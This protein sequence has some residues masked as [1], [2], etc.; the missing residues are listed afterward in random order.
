MAVFCC[1]FE[2]VLYHCFMR[3][4]SIDKYADTDSFK[5]IYGLDEAGRGPWAGPVVACALMFKSPG[6][7]HGCNDSKALTGDERERL[8][9]KLQD[10]AYY[11]IGMATHD[12]ID[13]MGLRKATNLAFSRAL[14]E[15]KTKGAPEPDFLLIDGRDR[16]Q[17]PYPFKTIIK[18]DSKVRI[19]SAASIMAKVSRDRL[20][21]E[22]AVK[23]PDYG[24]EEHKGYGT[25]MHQKAIAKNGLCE[26]H[27]KS[28]KPVAALF[29]AELPLDF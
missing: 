24:F 7:V 11:G 29:K 18:G 12:D 16:W 17:F 6:G 20:M 10:S 3:F 21:C 15:L 1:R 23:Y 2:K 28:Y 5:A 8:F 26:I 25:D 19:I 14:E 27:R 9:L 13:R 4:D 22:Y